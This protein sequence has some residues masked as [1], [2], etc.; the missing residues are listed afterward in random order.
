V[1][2]ACDVK[3]HITNLASTSQTPQRSQTQRVGDRRSVTGCGG[4]RRAFSGTPFH[5]AH[6]SVLGGIVTFARLRWPDDLDVRVSASRAFQLEEHLSVPNLVD[7][8]REPS[9]A[10]RT[11]I[12]VTAA[13]HRPLATTPDLGLSSKQSD[14]AARSVLAVDA[15]VKSNSWRQI[16]R[17]ALATSATALILS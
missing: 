6:V 4:A 1:P 8:I 16:T 3:R 13:K 15:A 11:P 10:G 5:L 2:S 12:C 14:G 17:S 9:V 7:E